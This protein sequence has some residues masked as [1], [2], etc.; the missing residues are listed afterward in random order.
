MFTDLV[1]GDVPG[2]ASYWN[3]LMRQTI[4]PC[5]SGGRPSSPHTGMHAYETNTGQLIKWNGAAW[6]TVAGSRVA[7]NPLPSLTATSVNPT[8]GTGSERYCWYTFGPGPTVNYNFFIKFGSS[9]VNAGSGT[10]SVSTPIACGSVYAGGH[11]AVGSLMLADASAGTF[12]VNACYIGNGA[13]TISM[14]GSA[15]V[16]NT[17][18]WVWTVGD[19]L[20]GSITYPV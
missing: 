7:N 16:T 11:P 12:T 1:T 6:E 18:P 5:T 8:L 9:G 20:A 15:P 4:I 10:Y 3:P 17:F 2:A 14:V 13:S 19:Y